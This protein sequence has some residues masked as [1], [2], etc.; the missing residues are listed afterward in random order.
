MHIHAFPCV[1]RSLDARLS[2]VV[3]QSLIVP[4]GVNRPPTRYFYCS[5]LSEFVNTSHDCRMDINMYTSVAQTM[6]YFYY[7]Q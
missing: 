3:G 1:L 7:E 6:L 5:T 2:R 4:A